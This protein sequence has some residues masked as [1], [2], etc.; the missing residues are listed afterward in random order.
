MKLL[1]L[2]FAL[3]VSIVMLGFSSNPANGDPYIPSGKG[4][5]IYRPVED[6]TDDNRDAAGTIDDLIR[7]GCFNHALINNSLANLAAYVNDGTANSD[8]SGWVAI[9][10][11]AGD[12]NPENYPSFSSPTI[13]A[14]RNNNP[15]IRIFGWHMLTGYDAGGA[16]A[17]AQAAEALRKVNN[18]QADQADGLILVPGYLFY[19]KCLEDP[20]YAG[21]F[22]QY[23]KNHINQNMTLG[24]SASMKINDVI[25][26]PRPEHDPVHFPPNTDR[27]SVNANVAKAVNELFCNDARVN[28][29]MPRYFW[30]KN[31]SALSHVSPHL[32][33]WY[34]F[35][36]PLAVIGQC[37]NSNSKGSQFIPSFYTQM[38]NEHQLHSQVQAYTLWELDDFGCDD[39]IAWRNVPPTF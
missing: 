7:A 12:D 30:L 29:L 33:K 24:F 6:A 10:S 36:K 9:K 26:D 19:R 22:L 13:R 2:G 20:T 31:N 4:D 32:S 18:G 21:T 3:C 28:V 8:R 15:R 25:I 23:I 35:G 5:W 16:T 34:G 14:F 17:Q 38:F 1:N 27:G 39:A 37:H 11:G